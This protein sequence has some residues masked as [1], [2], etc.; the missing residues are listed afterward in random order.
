MNNINSTKTGAYD[1]EIHIHPYTNHSALSKH[2]TTK[3]FEK[4][5]GIYLFDDNQNKYIDAVSGL[6]SVNL[7]YSCDRIITA[8]NDQAKQLPFGSTHTWSTNQPATFLI[9]KLLELSNDHFT[10]A[11]LA[12]SGSESIELAAYCASQYWE[13][14]GL[15]NKNKILCLDGAYHGSTLLT[16]SLSYHGLDETRNRLGVISVPLTTRNGKKNINEQLVKDIESIIIDQNPEQVS[17]FIM[18]TVQLRNGVNVP[19][20]DFF[21]L[22][23]LVLK[24]HN[25]LLVLDESVTGMGRLGSWYGYQNFN[26]SPN[27]A[28]V[29]KGLSSGYQPLSA[30]LVDNKIQSEIL[31][32][33]QPFNAGFSTSGHPIACRA[34][35]AALHEIDETNLLHQLVTEKI[36]LFY[37]LCNSLLEF[38][39]IKSVRSNGLLGAIDFGETE[40]SMQTAK[41]IKNSCFK[42]RLIVRNSRGNILLCPP[43]ITSGSEMKNIFDILRRIIQDVSCK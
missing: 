34:A 22:L 40:T 37:N 29:S 39:N 35:L 38:E 27:M 23:E 2:G 33:K 30:L 7:G 9:S 14:R 16:R 26:A 31:N 11:I 18:E 41:M 6:W 36:P 24:K 15:E 3:V 10:A 5:Q 12:N 32:S 43:L 13:S 4:G 42:E 25:V 20:P 8:I 1:V 19:D 28:I 21:P 17:F